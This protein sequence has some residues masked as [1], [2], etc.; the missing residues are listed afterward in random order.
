MLETF[1]GRAG[2]SITIGDKII[3][4]KTRIGGPETTIAI[5]R[6]S[7]TSVCRSMC[8]LPFLEK[9]LVITADGKTYKIK[10]LSMKLIESVRSKILK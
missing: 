10:R 4:I 1:N 6:I 9:T 2:S 8:D 7:S 5:D 3:T